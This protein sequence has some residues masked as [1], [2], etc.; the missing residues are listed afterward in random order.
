MIPKDLQLN[1]RQREALMAIARWEFS[2][3]GTISPYITIHAATLKRL[4]GLG[5]IRGDRQATTPAGIVAAGLLEEIDERERA[6]AIRRLNST[7]NP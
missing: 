5:L 2:P 3:A 6:A 7:V 4:T 1:E